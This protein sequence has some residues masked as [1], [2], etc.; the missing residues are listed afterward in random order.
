MLADLYQSMTRIASMKSFKV[1]RPG[2]T[3]QGEL[4]VFRHKGCIIDPKI[5][6]THL[7]AHEDGLENR[8]G[9][10]F[11]QKVTGDRGGM[12]WEI[13]RFAA[14]HDAVVN[15]ELV[16]K[17]SYHTHFQAWRI[18]EALQNATGA[19]KHELRDYCTTPAPITWPVFLPFDLLQYKGEDIRRKP[20]IERRAL[21]KGMIDLHVAGV[22]HD[23]NIVRDWILRWAMD[24]DD[25]DS[26]MQSLDW[27]G[28]QE[29]FGECLEGYVIKPKTSIYVGGN[30]RRIVR[31]RCFR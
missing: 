19:I 18:V 28:Q 23:N 24:A 12:E 31:L 25:E 4:D 8:H 7:L 3:I 11:S 15:G 1:Q 2:I 22:G 27:E 26:R 20:F 9:K 17:P 16:H 21:L 13:T 29:F 30:N 6:G 10:P 5:D 14:A